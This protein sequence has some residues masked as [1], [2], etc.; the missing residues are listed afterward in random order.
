[1]QRFFQLN[2]LSDD[3][4]CLVIASDLDRARQVVRDVSMT[5]DGASDLRLDEAEVRGIAT[6]KELDE[7]DARLSVRTSF[8]V[9]GRRQRPLVQE[10]LEGLSPTGTWFPMIG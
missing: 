7:D 8:D 1:M 2:D 9:H 3:R 6:W 4:H 10:G 5:F